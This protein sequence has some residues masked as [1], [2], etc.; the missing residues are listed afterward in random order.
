MFRQ[1]L[2]GACHPYLPPN[3]LPR[4]RHSRVGGKERGRV[5]PSSWPL[6]LLPDLLP[7]DHFCHVSDS[8]LDVLLLCFL[9]GA[10]VAR[11]SALSARF[12][13][14]SG[15]LLSVSGHLDQ[16]HPSLWAE[17]TGSACLLPRQL[18]PCPRPW[19]FHRP[20][21]LNRP[22]LPLRWIRPRLPIRPRSR[23]SKP[24]EPRRLR[25]R[26]GPFSRRTGSARACACGCSAGH[27]D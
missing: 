27:A 7:P 3:G 22:C 19:P 13:V 15:S 10:V 24:S 23:P 14:S 21:P 8:S 16:W 20:R 9:S 26:P 5:S 11:S 6:L 25:P 18:H 12:S 1:G 2:G 4:Q 17:H